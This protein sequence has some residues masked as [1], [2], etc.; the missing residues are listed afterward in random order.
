MMDYITKFKEL[1]FGVN[2]IYP[3]SDIGIA[4]LFYDIHS[5]KLIFVSERQ[6]FC[7]SGGRCPCRH[8]RRYGERD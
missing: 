3:Q 4:R 7:L 1:G 6:A 5:N 8:Y 2:P